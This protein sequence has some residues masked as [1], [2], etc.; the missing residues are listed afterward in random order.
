MLQLQHQQPT[1]FVSQHSV[2][3]SVLLPPAAYLPES[4][5][6]KKTISLLAELQREH[7]FELACGAAGSQIH[8]H[9]HHQLQQQ[10][11][12]QQACLLE[13]SVSSVSSTA[14]LLET[15]LYINGNRTQQCFQ[16]QLPSCELSQLDDC[17][18]EGLTSAQLNYNVLVK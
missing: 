5:V 8:N 17:E 18:M 11:K 16:F 6:K 9:H 4:M 1:Q 15:N 10:Q 12:Q 14:H 13:A 2:P 7:S 3:P